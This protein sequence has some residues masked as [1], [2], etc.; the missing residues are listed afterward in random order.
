M[1]GCSFEQCLGEDALNFKHAQGQILQCR[2]NKNRSDAIDLDQSPVPVDSCVFADNGGD[3]IDIS[4]S[5]TLLQHNVILGSADKGISCG[6]A[7]TVTVFDTYISGC[8][9]AIAVKDLSLARIV[10]SSLIGNR[11]AV[12]GFQKKAAFG[13]GNRR[14]CLLGRLGKPES[15]GTGHLVNLQFQ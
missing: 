11:A 1:I 13:G 4:G 10:S 7:S 2:F 3:A 9:M 5:R 15:G 6:E 12:V 14:D 8:P